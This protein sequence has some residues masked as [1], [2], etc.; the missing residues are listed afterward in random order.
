MKLPSL[1]KKPYVNLKNMS[2]E[3]RFPTTYLPSEKLAHN[4][5]FS[6][7]NITEYYGSMGCGVFKWGM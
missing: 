4:V 7:I 5:Q 2:V 6:I 1:C 3:D